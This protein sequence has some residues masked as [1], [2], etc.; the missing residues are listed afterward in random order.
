MFWRDVCEELRYIVLWLYR[1][2]ILEEVIIDR[3]ELESLRNKSSR[4]M[5]GVEIVGG[6]LWKLVGIRLWIRVIEKN[7]VVRV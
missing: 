1:L 5:S 2:G 7:Y 6:E 4:L 3:K